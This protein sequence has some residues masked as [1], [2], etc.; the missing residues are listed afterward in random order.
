M[1]ELKCTVVTPQKTILDM[2]ASFVSITLVDGEIGI[3][4]GHAPLLGRVAPG[5]L[6]IVAVETEDDDS[7][8]DAMYYVEGGFLE[9]IDGEVAILTQRA[10]PVEEIDAD[11]AERLL[12]E[13]REMPADSPEKMAV[14]DRAVAQQRARIRVARHTKPLI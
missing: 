1:A 2:R 10:T 14:R 5:R 8:A 7:A 4:P 3:A 13:A 11:Q 6:H 12:A 9:V